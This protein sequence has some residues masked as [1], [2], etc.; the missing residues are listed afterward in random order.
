M[1]EKRNGQL[2]HEPELINKLE[3]KCCKKN[4]IET[5]KTSTQIDNQKFDQFYKLYIRLT[6]G[7]NKER[8]DNIYNLLTS[9]LR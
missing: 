6:T 9:N 8:K 5:I 2:N 1:S 7:T 4:C 3:L